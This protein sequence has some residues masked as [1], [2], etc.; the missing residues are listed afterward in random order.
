[1]YIYNYNAEQWSIPWQSPR[2][3]WSGRYNFINPGKHNN[4]SSHNLSN[5][6]E[7]YLRHKTQLQVYGTC[8][9]YTN[10]LKPGTYNLSLWSSVVGV[11]RYNP[12]VE[13][14]GF[15]DNHCNTQP[16][17]QAAHLIAVNRSTQYSTLCG[18][19]N[20]VSAFRITTTNH[21]KMNQMNSQYNCNDSIR[22]TVFG[23]IIINITINIFYYYCLCTIDYQHMH[24]FS[25]L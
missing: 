13:S 18:M 11:G 24:K 5:I 22:N 15:H 16:W 23:I 8:D 25:I 21:H 4:T 9:I 7:C 12:I 10:S 17:A 6:T 1:M 20:S 2:S 3:G 19:I 14:C